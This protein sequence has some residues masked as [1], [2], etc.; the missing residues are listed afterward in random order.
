[1]DR[2]EGFP[3]TE[4]K[5][6]KALT[7]NNERAWFQKHKEE[8]EEGWNKPMKLLLGEVREKI[9][10]AYDH[11]DLDDPKVFRI[12]RD[13]RFAKDKSPYKTN[14]GGL[15]P[16]KRTGKK[17]TDLP[18]ALY[19][20]V[21]AGEIFAAAGHYMM[22]P[23]SL[24]RFRKAVAEEKTGKELEKILKALA[25][26]GFTVESHDSYARVPK[27][28]DANHPRAEHLRRKGLH[29]SFPEV[30]KK[31]LTTRELPK[32]LAKQ[33]AVATD[34]VEWLVFATA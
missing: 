16:L 32:W 26:K 12:Y 4:G 1:M 8:F 21:G 6:W 11:A 18:M 2:F 13:V 3:D 28:F 27:G 24:A 22:E 30:P 10:S 33:C 5:F 23:E 31:L 20:H 34:L 19:F 17:I 15:I 7:K 25:K 14:I 9:D 29:V